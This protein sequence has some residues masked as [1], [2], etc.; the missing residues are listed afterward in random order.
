MTVDIC[1]QQEWAGLRGTLRDRN[2][3]QE[4]FFFFKSRNSG[5]NDASHLF[6]KTTIQFPLPIYILILVTKKI[7]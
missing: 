4:L 7:S 2:H 5:S 1:R 6:V 3:V